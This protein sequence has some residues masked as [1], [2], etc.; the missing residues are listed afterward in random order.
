MTATDT[1]YSWFTMLNIQCFT[2]VGCPTC[3]A[4]GLLKIQLQQFEQSSHLLDM[5]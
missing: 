1:G 2:A 5:E 4:A 3:A